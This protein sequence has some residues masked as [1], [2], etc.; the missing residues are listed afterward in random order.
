M[1]F[2]KETVDLGD[3]Q[4]WCCE[5]HGKILAEQRVWFHESIA[6]GEGQVRALTAKQRWQLKETKRKAYTCQFCGV[7]WQRNGSWTQARAHEKISAELGNAHSII[8]NGERVSWLA[9]A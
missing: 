6:L 9:E 1:V 7:T 4:V 5:L 3:G 2:G 8:Q